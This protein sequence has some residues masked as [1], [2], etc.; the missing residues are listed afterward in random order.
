MYWVHSS[1]FR[2]PRNS[3]ELLP[4]IIN[5]VIFGDPLA[6]KRCNLKRPNP[7][8]RYLHDLQP[9]TWS[10]WEAVTPAITGHTGFSGQRSRGR[11]ESAGPAS[12]SD[13]PLENW[14]NS[15]SRSD[16]GH[17]W[18]VESSGKPPPGIP[19]RST[20]AGSTRGQQKQA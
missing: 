11:G 6:E 8:V 18:N 3:I 1:I 9:A 7:I 14:W 4:A 16:R 17:G 2:F 10:S 12:C 20:V 19:G 15:K 13:L 5:S